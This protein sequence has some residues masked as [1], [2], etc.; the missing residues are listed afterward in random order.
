M[1]YVKCCTCKLLSSV[2]LGL[3][4]LLGVRLV[5]RRLLELYKAITKGMQQVLRS[6]CLALPQIPCGAA[7]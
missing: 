4:L 3:G 1:I 6:L 5:N 2:V 7:E